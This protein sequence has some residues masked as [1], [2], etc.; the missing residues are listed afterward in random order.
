LIYSAEDLENPTIVGI[1]DKINEDIDFNYVH[2]EATT[3]DEE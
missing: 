1:W 2:D 3:D